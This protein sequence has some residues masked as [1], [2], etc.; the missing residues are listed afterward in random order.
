M[1]QSGDFNLQVAPTL[2]I[3]FRVKWAFG[4]RRRI[5]KYIF[6]GGRH[7]VHL[8]FPILTILATFDLQVILILP[9]KLRVRRKSSK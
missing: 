2:P 4:L 8:I 3:K 9:P 6:Q 5:S 1:M 7:G